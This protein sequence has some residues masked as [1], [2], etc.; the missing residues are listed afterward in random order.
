MFF[1]QVSVECREREQNEQSTDATA[2][3]VLSKL[4]SELYLSLS[5]LVWCVDSNVPCALGCLIFALV[6]YFRFLC[7]HV[8]HVFLFRS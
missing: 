5:L 6:D 4:M 1:V 2:G 3:Q 7:G 8:I